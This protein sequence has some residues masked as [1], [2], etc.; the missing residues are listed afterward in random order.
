MEFKSM[1]RT[2]L[3]ICLPLAFGVLLL[4]FLY[5]KMDISVIMK[6]IKEDVRYD[7]IL[8]SL[9]FG[10]GANVIRALRWELLIH[11]SGDHPRRSNVIWAVLGN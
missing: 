11:S 1:L 8:F 3:K 9:L 7:I 10:A 6:V 4:W 2:I 5:R